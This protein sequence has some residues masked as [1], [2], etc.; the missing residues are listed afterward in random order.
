VLTLI[1]G[2]SYWPTLRFLSCDT[3][4]ISEV[5]V[6]SRV[7]ERYKKIL[8][9]SRVLII[10]HRNNF[11]FHY[12]ILN[13][14]TCLRH[15]WLQY[16]IKSLWLFGLICVQNSVSSL[17]LY[18][19]LN[20]TKILQLFCFIWVKIHSY[21]HLYPLPDYLF[22]TLQI[23]SNFM[24]SFLLSKSELLCSVSLMKHLLRD[25]F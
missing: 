3:K 1:Q 20:F 7:I 9:A 22:Q 8:W 5:S 17:I 15:V 13:S 14:K 4:T 19:S 12:H 18:N 6:V 24:W 16:D 10:G 21:I 25:L 2:F 23:Y 11:F